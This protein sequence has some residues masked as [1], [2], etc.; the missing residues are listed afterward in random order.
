MDS[1]FKHSCSQSA[2]SGWGPKFNKTKL[3]VC[4]STLTSTSQWV[5]YKTFSHLTVI[6]WSWSNDQITPD[7]R[8]FSNLTPDQWLFSNILDL[9]LTNFNQL[10]HA[11]SHCHRPLQWMN[12][13]PVKQGLLQGGC[14]HPVESYWW[15]QTDLL[16]SMNDGRWTDG[17][18]SALHINSQSPV[19]RLPVSLCQ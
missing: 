2:V 15:H 12:R 9:I 13:H 11:Q 1:C 19:A 18:R 8:L 14:C 3:L 4:T 6:D 7:Q 16:V 5:Q 10:P 17:L